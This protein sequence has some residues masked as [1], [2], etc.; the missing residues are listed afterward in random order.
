M[1]KQLNKKDLFTVNGGTAGC[2][3]TFLN[4]IGMNVADSVDSYA[5]N[6]D[7]DKLGKSKQIVLGLAFY[8]NMMD[9]IG[10]SEEDLTKTVDDMYAK[11]FAKRK[12]E[13]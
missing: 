13:F 2:K 11:E 12:I 4:F 7:K 3:R 8:F 10:F 9:D 1:K 5:R 6:R